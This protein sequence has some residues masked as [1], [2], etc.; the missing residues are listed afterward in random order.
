[1][2]LH[3][4]QYLDMLFGRL[5]AL[6]HVQYCYKWQH[7]PTVSDAFW[8]RIC[9]KIHTESDDTIHIIDRTLISKIMFQK[10]LK[11]ML[12]LNKMSQDLQCFFM[13]TNINH[14]TLFIFYTT[15]IRWNF[16]TDSYYDV[17]LGNCNVLQHTLF[18]LIMISFL[19]Y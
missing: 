13:H 6:Y 3:T 18:V 7:N 5:D 12:F 1:M 14:Y 10:H 16:R 2:L 8:V 19:I 9:C 17:C 15:F 11:W 4:C